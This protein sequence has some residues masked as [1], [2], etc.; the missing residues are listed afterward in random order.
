M[1]I[2]ILGILAAMAIPRYIALQSD[3]RTATVNG[4][5]GGVRAAAAIVYAKAVIGGTGAI[6]TGVCTD[7]CD[8]TET[9]SMQGQTIN[10]CYGYADATS[11]DEALVDATGF[12]DD[13]GATTI[14]FTANGTSSNCQVSYLEPSAVNVAPTTTPLTSGC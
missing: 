4:L 1:I 13:N 2:V 14:I 12:T 8:G 5:A 11:M 9:V 6:C 10:L 7:T 3:A